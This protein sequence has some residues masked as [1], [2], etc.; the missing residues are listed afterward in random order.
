MKIERKLFKD[1]LLALMEKYGVKV[2]CHYSADI[3]A[4]DEYYFEGPNR[5]FEVSMEDL[6]K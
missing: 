6:E 3:A 1:E 4:N 5:G 2:K